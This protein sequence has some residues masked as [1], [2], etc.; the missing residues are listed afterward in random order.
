MQK[1]NFRF[2]LSQ[3]GNYVPDCSTELHGESR[4]A[5]EEL[6]APPPP[7]ALRREAGKEDSGNQD[8]HHSLT[9]GYMEEAGMMGCMGLGNQGPVGSRPGARAG[10]RQVQTSEV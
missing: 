4:G 1:Q 2:P 6:R 5:E 9:G 3:L 10:S 7:E 8:S